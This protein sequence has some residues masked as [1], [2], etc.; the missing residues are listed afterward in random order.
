MG[1]QTSAL[2]G[3]YHVFE[4]TV[5]AF[6]EAATVGRQLALPCGSTIPSITASSKFEIKRQTSLR[7]N[8]NKEAAENGTIGQF[9]W[10][11]LTIHC[12]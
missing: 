9:L 11:S 12:I 7:R 10:V 2:T 3:G 8:A 4:I 5:L 6:P 1:T